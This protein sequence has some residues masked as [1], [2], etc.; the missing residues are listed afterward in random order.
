MPGI[1]RKVR[2]GD[3]KFLLKI[4]AAEIEPAHDA[5]LVAGIINISDATLLRRFEVRTL[6]ADVVS[7][8]GNRSGGYRQGR[9]ELPNELGDCTRIIDHAPLAGPVEVRSSALITR[10]VESGRAVVA[11]ELL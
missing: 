7:Q 9:F 4:V 1:E 3:D 10:F 8:S 5:A 11:R 6:L 2:D